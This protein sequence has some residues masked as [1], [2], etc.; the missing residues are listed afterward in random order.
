[1]RI[2]HI[3]FRQD[4]RT[5]RTRAYAV[6]T[7]RK[8]VVE[9]GYVDEVHIDMRR[10]SIFKR[11]SQQVEQEIQRATGIIEPDDHTLKFPYEG[12]A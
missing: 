8:K 2:D 3:Y 9:L 11:A 4:P 7:G 1:M 12:T 10:G 5:Q 6:T